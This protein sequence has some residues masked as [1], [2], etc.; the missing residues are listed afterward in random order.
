[1]TTAER[2]RVL[3]VCGA[4]ERGGAETVLLTLVRHLDRARFEPLAVS[5]RDGPVVRELA[6][7]TGAGVEVLPSPRFRN[8]VRG[9]RLV[10]GL[11]RFIRARQVA[12]VHANGAGPQLYAGLA[13]WRAGVPSVYHAHDLVEPGWAGQS[14]IQRLALRV[15]A[16][17]IVAVSGYAAASLRSAGARAPVSVVYNGV[18]VDRATQGL[19]LSSEA[20]LAAGGPSVVWCGRLQRW[21]GPHIFLEAAARVRRRVPSARF[22][23]VG[24]TAFG[25]EPDL[26]DELARLRARLGLDDAL[27]FAGYL[28]DPRP[29]LAKAAVVVHSSL[30]PEPLGMVVLE[31]MALGKAVVASRV[32]GVPEVIEDGTSG[33]L[34]PPDALADAVAGLLADDARRA[35]LGAAARRRVAEQFDAARAARQIEAIYDELLAV[36]WR[37]RAGA[38]P[39][40]VRE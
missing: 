5:L 32:G 15:P 9:A 26:G 20:C 28:A 19:A 14:V 1:V 35:Q 17:A 11:A 12:V 7:A 38:F 22:V 16:R 18:D 8:L 3:Y 25:L 13:A 10:S 31:A 24:G 27:D 2:V 40:G 36:R 4:G 21:K 34:L 29:A 37:E 6:A 33:I 39:S 23:V 30:R